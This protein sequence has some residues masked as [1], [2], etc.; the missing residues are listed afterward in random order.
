MLLFNGNYNGFVEKFKIIL[1]REYSKLF[2]TIYVLNKLNCIVIGPYCAII[3]VLVTDIILMQYIYISLYE[4]V[5][6]CQTILDN[7][8]SP[9]TQIMQ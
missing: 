3:N 4:L 7:I 6:T 9:V 2:S 8:L 5:L 1:N